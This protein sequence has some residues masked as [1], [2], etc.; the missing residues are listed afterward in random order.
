MDPSDHDRLRIGR[1]PRTPRG[2]VLM[3][4]GGAE[5]GLHEIDQRSLSYRR[6]LWMS[7][8]I[9]GPLA[10]AQVGTA[11]L[12]FKVKGWNAGHAD[13]PSPVADARE[14]LAR[15]RGQHPDLPIVL[16]GHSMGGRTA[17]WVADEPGV[18]GIV[19]IAPWWPADDPV[20]P[21]AGKH[22]VGV[23]GRRDRI[24]SARATERYLERA[25]AVAGSTRFVDMGP[26]GHYMLSGVRRWNAAAIRESLGILERHAS[27][28][29]P[30]P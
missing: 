7:D 9:A 30:G 12:R 5:R 20:R 22:V 11:V 26:R 19:G 1:L 29:P 2:L 10:R 24:T 8:S 16:L 13:G 21:L 17:A 25:R 4:H 14:A 3:L 18:V 6:A 23:H 15:L 27:T 28:S